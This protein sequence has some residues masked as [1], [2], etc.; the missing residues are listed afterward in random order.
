MWAAPWFVL[1]HTGTACLPALSALLHMA[2]SPI[3][4]SLAEIS[5]ARGWCLS[6]EVKAGAAEMGTRGTDTG[7]LNLP[8]VKTCTDL[9]CGMKLSFFFYYLLKE[10][11]I[12]LLL[13]VSNTKC[14]T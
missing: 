14:C 5:E 13:A 1:Q 8:N 2:F 11:K 7:G 9:H 4:S 10:R 12:L 6:P 3:L